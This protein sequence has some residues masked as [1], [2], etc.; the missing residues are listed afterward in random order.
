MKKL[1]VV[2]DGMIKRDDIDS[3]QYH[4]IFDRLLPYGVKTEY[5]YDDGMAKTLAPGEPFSK[6][7]LRIEKEGPEWVEHSPE[8]LASIENAD[9]IMVNFSAAG[10]SLLKH[11]KKLD[12]LCVCRS[13]TENVN[14]AAAKELGIKVCNAPGRVAG[15]VADFAVAL[16]L[17]LNR[18]IPQ[19]N[20]I[21]NGGHWA[22]STETLGAG[23][24]LVKDAVVGLVGYGRIGH[25]VMDRL[26]GFGCSQFLAYDPYT[27]KEKAET[28]GV[29]LV[30]LEELMSSS[31]FVSIHARLSPE[32]ENLIG[33]KEISLMK[34]S[35][36]LINT[37][38]AGLL[39]ENALIKALQEKRIRGAG[40]DVFRSEPLP[41]ESPL[42]QLDNVIL[43]P[44][45]AGAAGKPMVAS[46]EI[47]VE[48]L[49]RYCKNEPLRNLV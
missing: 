15:P 46:C 34:P 11:A 40:L 6:V 2:A 9:F 31:D 23:C 45:C 37:A 43:T 17:A 5:V 7:M 12:L 26:K 32:T 22:P 48:E 13:G 24:L 27:D 1:V 30:S 49:M 47:V 44:H 19:F 28:D 3:P 25:M 36:Y 35:A 4:A 10:T 14:V 33:E 21:H 18:R 29:K 16:M 41:Q 42:F 38:R 39:D 20:M 8:F